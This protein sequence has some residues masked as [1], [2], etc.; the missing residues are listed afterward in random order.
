MAVGGA[1]PRPR[2][3]SPRS[4]RRGRGVHRH[5]CATRP[6]TATRSPDSATRG[7]AG[8]P[9]TVDSRCGSGPRRVVWLFGDTL[10][11]AR[12]A[13]GAMDPGWTMARNTLVEQRDAC[14][15]PLVGSAGGVPVSYI[16]T[17]GADDWVWPSGV[18]VRDGVIQVMLL[19]VLSTPGPPGFRSPSPG[20]PP[21]RSRV[22]TS[23]SARSSTS[24]RCRVA[25]PAGT[26]T[27]GESLYVSGAD[28]YAYGTSRAPRTSP[29]PRSRPFP[30]AP[31]AC[32]TAG[33]GTPSSRTRSRCASSAPRAVRGSTSG[34]AAHP[35]TAR[36]ALD[37]RVDIDRARSG[38]VLDRDRPAGPVA[39]RG[40]RRHHR[41]VGPDRVRVRPAA[42]RPARRGDRARLQRQRP[43]ARAS[44]PTRRAT[45]SCSLSPRSL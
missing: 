42:R 7:S 27:F 5:G 33:A 25:L 37:D 2:R 3:R 18:F 28:V 1:V 29:A 13:D 26:V 4:L 21:R 16:A 20:S 11:G 41:G 36:A 19:R 22:T 8:S 6:T 45:A 9:A 38:V 40:H 12:T 10:V 35:A 23:R 15:R 31:G 39:R 17:P 43:R 30:P 24:P 14:L 32:G 34:R 44:K